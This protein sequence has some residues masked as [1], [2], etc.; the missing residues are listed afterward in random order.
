MADPKIEH[1]IR[2]DPTP[3]GVVQIRFEK[4]TID[5]QGNVVRQYHRTTVEPGTPLDAQME[6]V[7]EDLE[8]IGFEVPDNA[9]RN[10]MRAEVAAVHTPAVVSA[11][12]AARVKP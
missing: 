1:H 11:F 12:R 8:R 4:R 6:V 9:T 7:E 5:A 2:V 10:R 3:L